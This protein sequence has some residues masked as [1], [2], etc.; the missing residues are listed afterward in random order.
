[1]NCTLVCLAFPPMLDTITFWEKM[2][3]ARLTK[4]VLIIALALVAFVTG[5]TAGIVALVQHHINGQ[6]SF[7]TS[8]GYN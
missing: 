3:C 1:M 5:T 8:G 2:N 7:Q 6:S 4:N